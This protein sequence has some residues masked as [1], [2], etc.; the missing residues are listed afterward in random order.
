MRGMGSIVEITSL[1]F[2]LIIPPCNGVNER[3]F[4]NIVLCSTPKSLKFIF[5]G[6]RLFLVGNHIGMTINGTRCTLCGLE[7]LKMNHCST[8][9]IPWEIYS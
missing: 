9:I 6:I 8:T 3:L 2:I 1:D 5:Y 4:P 7:N